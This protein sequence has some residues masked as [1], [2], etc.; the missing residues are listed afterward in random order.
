M[1]GSVIDRLF[2]NLEKGTP[3]FALHK[4]G[5]LVA[6]NGMPVIQTR[7]DTVSPQ[8]SGKL[9]DPL[10]MGFVVPGVGDEDCRMGGHGVMAVEHA[11]ACVYPKKLREYFPKLLERFSDRRRW[12]QL[13]YRRW[14]TW[15]RARRNAAE[16]GLLRFDRG[17]RRFKI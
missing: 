13:T 14:L 12:N 17:Y 1:S 4:L 5:Q 10:L 8:L 11:H 6:R 9:S 16:T 15:N 3:D 7:V 2:V